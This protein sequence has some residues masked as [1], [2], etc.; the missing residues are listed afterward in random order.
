[1]TSV[2]ISHSRQL[3]LAHLQHLRIFHDNFLAFQRASRQSVSLL[4]RSPQPT[5]HES[6]WRDSKSSLHSVASVVPQFLRIMSNF[7]LDHAVTRMHTH[8]CTPQRPQQPSHAQQER[9]SPSEHSNFP[10]TP[11]HHHHRLHCFTE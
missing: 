9:Y 7:P 8:I 11:L 5:W 1:M 10:S 6:R 3:F 2:R 4:R